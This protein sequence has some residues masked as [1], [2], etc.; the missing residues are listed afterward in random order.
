[1]YLGEVVGFGHTSCQLV[2]GWS[3]SAAC[4][5]DFLRKCPVLRGTRG[6]MVYGFLDRIVRVTCV[7]SDQVYG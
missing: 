3:C 7:G 6:G 2:A 4:T 1:M 5:W